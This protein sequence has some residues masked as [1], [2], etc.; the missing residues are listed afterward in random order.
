MDSWYSARTLEL[1]TM[2]QGQE[3]KNVK[4]HLLFDICR[5]YIACIMGIIGGEPRISPAPAVSAKHRNGGIWNVLPFDAD[6]CGSKFGDP[7]H[8]AWR[9][10]LAV[11]MSCTLG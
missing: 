4:T 11:P 9:L 5:S 1:Q 10:F 6:V 8:P 3:L 2:V 7:L